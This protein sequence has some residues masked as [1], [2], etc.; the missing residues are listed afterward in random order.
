MNKNKEKNYYGVICISKDLNKYKA[1][2]Y[3]ED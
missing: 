1:V 2:V 3:I